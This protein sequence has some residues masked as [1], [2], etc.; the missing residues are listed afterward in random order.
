MEVDGRLILNM[1]SRESFACLDVQA[2]R[3]K[4]AILGFLDQEAEGST[5]RELSVVLWD[6]IN[7]YGLLALVLC[8]TDSGDFFQ[9]I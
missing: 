6:P 2:F 1:T 4:D 8:P 7:R 3:Q 9:E 5:R